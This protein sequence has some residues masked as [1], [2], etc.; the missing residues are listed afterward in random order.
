MSLKQFL[1]NNAGIDDG[2]NLDED[3]LIHLYHNIVQNEIR[4]EQREYIQSMKEG[5]L[6]KQGGRIKYAPPRT[7]T[8][9]LRRPHHRAAPP[10]CTAA[11]AAAHTATHGRAAPP[12]TS[13]RCTAALHPPRTSPRCTRRAAPAALHP[14]HCT[15]R[16]A[17]AALHPPRCRTATPALPVAVRLMVALGH[18]LGAQDVAQAV[19]DP[20]GQ[21]AVLL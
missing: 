4:M 12:R 8:A 9:I 13:P 6:L 20:V 7:R 3:M 5:W 1:R 11:H 2:K 21:R 19:H 16:A 10:C 14:P 15:R 18:A 17:P